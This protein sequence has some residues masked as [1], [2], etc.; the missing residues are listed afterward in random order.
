ME[1]SFIPPRYLPA[2]LLEA[3]IGGRKDPEAPAPAVAPAAGGR[4]SEGMT[5]GGA[6]LRL[7]IV[8]SARRDSISFACS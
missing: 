4:G 3:G 7:S 8:I 2:L 1:I 5:M 6:S